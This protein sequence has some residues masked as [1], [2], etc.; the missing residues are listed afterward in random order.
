MFDQCD[1]ARPACGKC[2]KANR[3]C[4]GYSEGLDLVLRHQN[5]A[6]K[7]GVDRRVHKNKNRS[8]TPENPLEPQPSTALVVPHP[9]YE[10]EETNAL[11][12]F[13]STFVLYG[14]D[15]QADRGFI[16]LLPLLFNRLRVG[17]PLS[18]CLAAVSNIL[19]GMW[20]RKRHGAERYAL[21][22]YAKALETTRVALQDPVESVSDETLMAV[23]LLG[24]YE[25][26]PI[27]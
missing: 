1:E 19:F 9:L 18:L 14:R 15:T 12:F 27:V 6:A 3:I 23:C 25:V 26:R 4:S 16:E 24:F 7:S 21:P 8:Q 10:S 5:T 22:S 20:E 17:S 2:V 13:V 11:C